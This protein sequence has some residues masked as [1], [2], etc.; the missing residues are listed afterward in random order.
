MELNKSKV[1]VLAVMILIGGASHA[2]GQSFSEWFRQKKTQKKYLVKQIV[3]LNF[4]AG[5]IKK[6]YDIASGG[7]EMVRGFTS[8]EFNLHN[9]FISSL[10]NVSPAVRNH[11]KVA[12]I[13]ALQI[14]ISKAF[15]GI[16]R[17]DTL[18]RSNQNYVQDV[19]DKV[20]EECSKDLEELLL[21]IGSGKMEM[22]DDQRLERLEK[23]YTA[24]RDKSAF[25]QSFCNQAGILI[26]QRE[27]E[28]QLINQIRNSYGITN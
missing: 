3:A 24:M 17:S 2:F 6:G 1:I 23:V 27:N 16:Q 11:V 4:Y 22:T 21:V 14:F 26:R 25:T 19:R 13:I 12:E 28:Q 8:G 7:L 18:N 20:M 10:K 9:T 5:N 15:N